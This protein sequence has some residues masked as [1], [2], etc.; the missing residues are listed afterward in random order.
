M[1]KYNRQAIQVLHMLEPGWSVACAQTV[2]DGQAFKL[3]LGIS[4]VRPLF[5]DLYVW[6]IRLPQAKG[7]LIYTY[8]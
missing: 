4:M 7:F 1:I 3:K 6:G 2:T 5:A 8:S